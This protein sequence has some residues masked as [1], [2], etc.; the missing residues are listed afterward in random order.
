MYK[1]TNSNMIKSDAIR[2]VITILFIVMMSA[3]LYAL[4]VYIL[5]LNIWIFLIWCAVLISGNTLII[6]YM[7]NRFLGKTKNLIY[8]QL[9]KLKRY[10]Q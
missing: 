10:S 3:L 1:I 2:G 7:T 6:E 8:L 9:M 5:P 4:D